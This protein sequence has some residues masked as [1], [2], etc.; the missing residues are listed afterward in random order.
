ME[1]LHENEE[2]Q[3]LC[4]QDKASEIKKIHFLKILDLN[5]K[6]GI[7][8]TMTLLTKKYSGVEF[9]SMRSG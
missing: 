9:L 3:N 2:L 4:Y 6:K 7:N 1:V 5:K 8:F